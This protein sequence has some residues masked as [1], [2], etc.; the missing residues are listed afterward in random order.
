MRSGFAPIFAILAVAAACRD[1]V[2]PG[3]I[4]A[5]RQRPP[6]PPPPVLDPSF[7]TFTRDGL[8][9]PVRAVATDKGWLL[10]TDARLRMITRVDPVSLLPDQAFRVPSA[11]SA[12]GLLGGKVLVGNPGRQTVDLYTAQ[13][14]T[15]VGSV[16]PGMVGYASD[17]ATDAARGLA[18]VLDQQARQVKVFDGDGALLGLI[19]GAGTGTTQ[20]VTPVGVALDT[21]RQ[22]VLVSD[23]G[24]P[25]TVMAS[26]KIYAYDGTYL[27]QISGAGRCG[28]L[29]CSGGFSRP[30]GLAVSGLG[31]V[32]L[33]DALLGQVLVYDRGTKALLRTLG[34]YP[35]LYGPSDI[36]IGRSD[37]VFVVSNLTAAVVAF[38]GEA[39]R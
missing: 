19:G 39:A 27:D 1:Q 28:M 3:D 25:P 9:S 26:V 33:A 35:T 38:R 23:Y 6:P 34:G 36:V 2:N 32:F 4:S 17:I 5:K 8:L 24:T 31:R 22:E 12:V 21:L 37:D 11:P 30:Q 29:G 10:V 18:F 20:L 15:S 14:G 13:G 16:G 7:P